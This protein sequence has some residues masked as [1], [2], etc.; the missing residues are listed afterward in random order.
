MS[1]QFEKAH[2]VIEESPTLPPRPEFHFI[3]KGESDRFSS[4]WKSFK[5]SVRTSD[6]RNLEI[7]PERD[8][9]VHF[10][11]TTLEKAY[12]FF[13]PVEAKREDAAL[14]SYYG[15]LACAPADRKHLFGHPPTRSPINGT[16]ELNWRADDPFTVIVSRVSR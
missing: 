10:N 8:A 6:F 16:F 9:P 3:I 4:A 7:T 14:A 5:F 12:R 2:Q 15:T 1:Q 13:I 11:D